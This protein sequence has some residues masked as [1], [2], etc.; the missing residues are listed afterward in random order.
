MEKCLLC[1]PKSLAIKTMAKKIAIAIARVTI[2]AILP[3][4]DRSMAQL[5]VGGSRGRG[6]D[7]S[8]RRAAMAGRLGQELQF[9]PAGA[10]LQA[11]KDRKKICAKDILDGF[12]T[13]EVPVIL[14]LDLATY[15]GLSRAFVLRKCKLSTR[16]HTIGHALFGGAWVCFEDKSACLMRLCCMPCHAHNSFQRLFILRPSSTFATLLNHICIAKRKMQNSP[17]SKSFVSEIPKVGE[18]RQSLGFKDQS[19]LQA[20]IFNDKLRAFRRQYRTSGGLSG[21]E[22][23]RW[24]SEEQQ[25]DLSQMVDEFLQANGAFFWPDGAED[26]RESGEPSRPRYSADKLMCVARI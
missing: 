15:T 23:H 5:E 16:K 6:W 1:P 8:T 22:L 24:K 21:A 3:A 13:K 25:A 4:E 20:K 26:G 7:G 9:G 11:R 12:Y 18:L 17:E 10:D 14:P 19:L 2:E